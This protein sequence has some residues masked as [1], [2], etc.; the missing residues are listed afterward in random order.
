MRISKVEAQHKILLALDRRPFHGYDLI[1]TL[2]KDFGQ[3]RQ[4]TIYRWLRDME[5]EGL[6]TSEIEPG[7]HGPDRRVYRVGSRGEDYLRRSLKQSIETIL[8]FYDD[9]RFSLSGNMERYLNAVPPMIEKGRIL[10]IAVP[11]MNE[12]DCHFVEFLYQRRGEQPID[13]LGD[14]SLLEK[15][16]I[17]FRPVR[18]E[19]DNIAMR[20]GMFSEIWTLGIPERSDFPRAILEF[21]RVL[22]P[23]G[24]LRMIAPFV[25]FQPPERPTISE[26]VRATSVH[27]FPELGIVEG[28]EVGKIIEAHF[29]Y[30][31]ASEAFPALVLFWAFNEK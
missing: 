21:K 26:F 29:T 23:R 9:Y 16:P 2:R 15:C 27:L 5:N 6:V 3:V 28:S 25:Y 14:T 4:A 8:H 17:K 7:P 20:N 11:Q 24:R 12:R 19:P 31:G 22:A 1:Q 13:V 30:C 18:G 10:F